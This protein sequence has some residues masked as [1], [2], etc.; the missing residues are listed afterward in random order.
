MPTPP[1]PVSV[2]SRTS[3]RASN[4]V[5]FA[6]SRSR[7]IVGVGASGGPVA[8]VSARTGA[9]GAAPV[10]DR[11]GATALAHQFQLGRVLEDLRLQSPELGTRLQAEL[12]G[13]VCADALIG[14]EGVGLPAAAIEREHQLTGKPL[15]GRMRGDELLQLTGER[16][17]PTG[18]QIGLDAQ[19]ERLEPLFLQARDRGLGERLGRQVGERRPAPQSQGLAHHGGG[20]LGLPCGE[21]SPSLLDELREALRVELAGSQTQAIARRRRLDDVAV[22][23]RFAQPRDVHLDGLDRARRRL[24]APQRERQSLGADR[25][26]GVQQQQ[27]Q[28]RARLDPTQGQRSLLAANFK[29]PQDPELHRARRTLPA[30]PRRCQ[31]TACSACCRIAS[32][33][34]PA[35]PTLPSQ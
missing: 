10:V 28:D 5:T 19:L 6:T 4:D 7:P 24:L 9:A 2:T 17:V 35:Y 16:R 1:G 27:G 34:L 23:E 12:V 15:A 22:A 13:Q 32:V 26:T 18:G 8:A 21:R 20:L 29:R 31:R 3:A 25:L 11:Y 30:S 14:I 33:L